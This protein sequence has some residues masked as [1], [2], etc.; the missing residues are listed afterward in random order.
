MVL[1]VCFPSARPFIVL[2]VVLLVLFCVSQAFQPRGSAHHNCL[3]SA[4]PAAQVE[5]SGGAAAQQRRRSTRL[6]KKRDKQGGGGGDFDWYSDGMDEETNWDSFWKD[7]NEQSA[8][9]VPKRTRSFKGEFYEPVDDDFVPP[10]APDGRRDRRFRG[11]GGGDRLAPAPPPAVRG[12]YE[13]EEEALLDGDYGGGGGGVGLGLPGYASSGPEDRWAAQRGA[14]PGR[15]LRELST[16]EDL[17]GRE[18]ADAIV[19]EGD[20]RSPYSG[21]PDLLDLEFGDDDSSEEEDLEDSDDDDWLFYDPER[22]DDDDT[23]SVEEDSSTEE[24]RTSSS[25]DDDDLAYLFD[26]GEETE[27]GEYLSE[28]EMA[29]LGVP[30]PSAEGQQVDDDYLNSLPPLSSRNL[31]MSMFSPQLQELVERGLLERLNTTPRETFSW[32]YSAAVSDEVFKMLD[33]SMGNWGVDF[34]INVGDWQHAPRDARRTLED[35]ALFKARVMYEATGLPCI[36]EATGFEVAATPDGSG[37]RQ[38]A[39]YRF[40]RLGAHCDKLVNI[41]GPTSDPD[42]TTNYKTVI[43]YYDGELQLFEDGLCE[44]AIVYASNDKGLISASLALTSMI[45]VLSEAFGMRYLPE[46]MRTTAATLMD[47]APPAAAQLLRERILRDARALPNGIIDVSAFLDSNV[48]VNL[49]EEC[50]EELA[51]RFLRGRPNKILTMATTGLALALPMAARLQVPVVYARKQRSIVMADP[52]HVFYKSRTLGEDSELFLEKKHVTP[53]DRVLV[54]DDMLSGGGC[55][56]ALLRV[57]A[58]AGAAPV[59][60][61]VLIEKTYD[62]GR[63]YLAGH[64]VPV[65]SLAKIDSVENGVINV[66]EEQARPQQEELGMDYGRGSG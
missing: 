36:S 9:Q 56:D 40:N 30:P 7:T 6:F 44:C 31:K 14:R 4:K 18:F 48:D 62:G 25:D 65:E 32:S 60:V 17:L 2:V 42:R 52:H 61:A 26:D 1:V 28:E 46:G 29:A 22:D 10:A 12:F 21:E 47:E 45:Q 39:R 3:S 54:V 34:K 66:L 24:E 13:E 15:R 27:E 57:V 11:G 33:G 23:T 41:L 64:N 8:V 35:V 5:G 55:Q 53:E 59:G 19:H 16:A 58:A 20:R 50:A 51:G 63:T 43:C 38:N 37:A 49:M